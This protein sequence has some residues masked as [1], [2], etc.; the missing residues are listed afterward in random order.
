VYH[1]YGG[2]AFVLSEAS[3]RKKVAY[4]LMV[5]LMIKHL[6]SHEY[7]PLD[8]LVELGVFFL[9]AYE[10]FISDRRFRQERKKRVVF[11]EVTVNLL[12]LHSR[13]Q[14]ILLAA[15]SGYEAENPQIAPWEK[16]TK[17]WIRETDDFL[18]EHSQQASASFLQEMPTSTH[19]D[20]M[21]GQ[22][23]FWKAKLSTK[24]ANLRDII[25]KSNIYF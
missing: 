14:R 5:S 9:I 24:L 22:P 13:G 19:Y 3:P 21:V 10:I 16:S 11:G 18:K 6:L 2:K 23:H 20:N 7:G 17:E 4:F 15:P 25:E 1:D 8:R 12:D